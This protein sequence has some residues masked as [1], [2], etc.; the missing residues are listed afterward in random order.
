MNLFWNSGWKTVSG[1]QIESL[2]QRS[3]IKVVGNKKLKV[4]KF[5]A[6]QNGGA[7]LQLAS[8]YVKG[9]W[10]QEGA[11]GLSANYSKNEF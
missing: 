8:Y 1:L 9:P 5:E 2:H 4:A 10:K 7:I 6:Q 3:F 11:D